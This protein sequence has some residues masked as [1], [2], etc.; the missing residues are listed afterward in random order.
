MPGLY[1][2]YED[3]HTS[4]ERSGKQ[5]GGAIGMLCA[6]PGG[7][8]LDEMLENSLC[9]IYLNPLF[10]FRQIQAK[11]DTIPQIYSVSC[12]TSLSLSLVLSSQQA[13]HSNKFGY[14]SRIR[15][16]TLPV[17]VGSIGGK[18]EQKW[19]ES[20]FFSPCSANHNIKWMAYF[21]IVVFP[22]RP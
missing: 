2:I 20:F 1:P 8:P 14:G 6:S 13:T 16:Q 9:I 19:N 4:P 12:L 17:G 10:S 5:S 21:N 7:F 15:A 11:Q 18:V 22:I 3:S